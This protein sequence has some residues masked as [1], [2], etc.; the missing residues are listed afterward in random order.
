[1]EMVVG[2]QEAQAMLVWLLYLS[3]VRICARAQASPLL[4]AHTCLAFMQLSQDHLQG[5]S[6]TLWR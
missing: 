1:V 3:K 6:M 5:P 4:D 2:L